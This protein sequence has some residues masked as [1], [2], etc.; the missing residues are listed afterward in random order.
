[1]LAWLAFIVVGIVIELGSIPKD[2]LVFKATKQSK[3]K[4]KKNILRKKEGKR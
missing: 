2:Q 3:R 1:M 4:K